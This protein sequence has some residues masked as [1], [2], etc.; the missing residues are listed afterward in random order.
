M[1]D[2]TFTFVIGFDG[3]DDRPPT[4]LAI[5]DKEITGETREFLK[6]GNG[7]RYPF[8]DDENSPNITQTFGALLLWSIIA[9]YEAARDDLDTWFENGFFDKLNAPK[10]HSYYVKLLKETFD[11]FNSK[12]VDN[13]SVVCVSNTY[14]LNLTFGL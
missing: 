14:F 3:E 1:T 5:P 4:V 11:S 12:K 13:G 2:E 6:K 10:E 7:Y 8:I 9:G